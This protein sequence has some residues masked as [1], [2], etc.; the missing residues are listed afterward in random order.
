MLQ[1]R[2]LAQSD[3]NAYTTDNRYSQL[4]NSLYSVGN[5]VICTDPHLMEDTIRKYFNSG[6]LEHTTVS[7]NYYREPNTSYWTLNSNWID[8]NNSQ[9]S[10]NFGISPGIYVMNLYMEFDIDFDDIPENEIIYAY[11]TD[12]GNDPVIISDISGTLSEHAHT[13]YHGVDIDIYMMKYRGYA[14]TPISLMFSPNSVTPENGYQM[15][16]GDTLNFHFKLYDLIDR[17]YQFTFNLNAES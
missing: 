4:D 8:L 5:N 9:I 14:V 1:I 12:S 13:I 11:G 7:G 15:Q 6:V 3:L 16:S 10:V 2:K 17:D